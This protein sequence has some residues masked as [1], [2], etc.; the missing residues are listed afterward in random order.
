MR[1]FIRVLILISISSP[2]FSQ[3]TAGFSASIVKGCT[4]LTVQFQ[5]Q[6]TGP[7][8]EWFWDFGNG[9]T[10]TAQNPTVTYKTAG[11]FTVRLI[12]RNSS[13]ENFVTKANYIVVNA[14]P[15]VSFSV[16]SGSF[17]CLPVQTSFQDNSNMHGDTPQNWLWDFNDG[18][19]SNQQNPV[20]IYTV[21]GV[22]NVSLTVTSI[23]GCSS[24]LIRNSMV[25]AGNK[26]VVDFSASPL[27]GCAS[28]LRQFNDNSIGKVT[29]ASW[30]FGDGQ[31]S[32]QLNPLHHY[33]DTG[34]FLVN[35]IAAD[36]GCRSSTYKPRYIHVTGPVAGFAKV[37]NCANKKLV[38]YTDTSIG[39]TSRFW[40]LGDG[41]TSTN[42][43][44]IHTYVTPGTYYVK[45]IV[46][47]SSCNDTARDTVYADI[48]NPQIQ[49]TPA[50]SFYCRLDTINLSVAGYNTN[51]VDS[52]A[53]NFGDSISGFNAKYNSVEYVYKT[54]G[55]VT[56]KVYL[57]DLDLCVDS[58]PVTNALT[59]KGPVAAFDSVAIGCTG[60]DVQYID[61][62]TS[63]QNAAITQ[64]LWSFGDG[65]T[66]NTIGSVNYSYAFPGTY[67]VYL[68]VTDANGCSDSVIHYT[69]VA[70]SP[71]VNA[72][73][74]TLV[75]AGSSFTLNPTG[76]QTY[77]WQPNPDLSCTN[78]ANP[79]ATPTGTTSYYVTGTSN[80]CSVI[81]TLNVNV[82]QKELLVVQPNTYS[83]CA[84]D[85]VTLKASGTHSYH[86]SPTN[87]LIKPNTRSPIAFPDVTTNYTV[88]GKDSNNCFEDSGIVEVT[89]NSK[90]TVNII[91]STVQL[92]V[93]SSFTIL[94]SLSDDAKMLQ[95]SPQTDLSCYNCAEPVATVNK[96]T[97][98]TLTGTT[99][100]GCSSS[101]VITIS[102]I[103]NGQSFYLP[104]TF[105]PNN[106]GMN[107][108]FY[109][110]SAS[111]FTIKSLSIFNR[112][113]QLV[114]QNQNFPSNSASAGWNGKFNN[115]DLAA[116]VYI[117][118]MQI[119]CADGEKAIKKGSIT[120]LR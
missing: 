60:T 52:F 9:T 34:V 102:A 112:W 36:N 88:V 93:G 67:M 39:E 76:A 109:P 116:D 21:D 73:N 1:C 31:S 47:G 30:V 33:R 22:F 20:H 40:D 63:Y 68:K 38:T 77:K 43:N 87:T 42:K 53:W 37:I 4:P 6:S 100:Y 25:Q 120:L 99:A 17:G 58:F 107:D 35:Y 81:D 50:K 89:V 98:Y 113:G 110:R 26:P 101:D 80:G 74:D 84:G 91:D 14:T 11:S 71:V 94:T 56:P 104:N 49:I 103:C 55:I 48:G 8:T 97:T 2:A 111:A 23:H 106:D 27:F 54:A 57:Q 108:Y 16:L 92:L 28:T 59:I 19:T 96:T 85:S 46:T 115:N 62:T 29:S 69:N 70:V 12:V 95:W 44:V 105:S 118:V 119:E 45:L 82:Q 32:H 51:A 78:C 79:V 24:T 90:P 3:L 86:W 15:T 7:I 64:A 65:I 10:S 41:F 72:G 61:K 114:F 117:Y 66:S 75:C 13:L 5:D 83:I 18:A